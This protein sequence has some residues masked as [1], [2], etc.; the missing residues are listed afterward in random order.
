MNDTPTNTVP[1]DANQPE[2]T[3]LIVSEV[4][5]WWKNYT[6]WANAI[7]VVTL[8]LANYFGVQVDTQISA[9]VLA[10]LNIVLQSPRMATTKAKALARN[11]AIRARMFRKA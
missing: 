6:V 8:V 9:G 5:V 10:I 7:T 11:M 2:A 1:S 3:P 4:K